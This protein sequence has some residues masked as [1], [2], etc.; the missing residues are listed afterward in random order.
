MMLSFR[1]RACQGYEGLVV[2]LA[3]QAFWRTTPESCG[4]SGTFRIA[5]SSSPDMIDSVFNACTPSGIH[6]PRFCTL[7]HPY[8]F[9]REAFLLKA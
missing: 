3:R 4:A 2:R 5:H 9:E 7:K 1:V 6:S 8:D